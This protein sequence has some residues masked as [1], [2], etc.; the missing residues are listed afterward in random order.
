LNKLNAIKFLFLLIFQLKTL[1]L[2]QYNNII[3][4]INDFLKLIKTH[5]LIKII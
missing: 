4:I 3:L 5:I 1:N 2:K